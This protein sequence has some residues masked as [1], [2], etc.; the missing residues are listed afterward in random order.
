MNRVFQIIDDEPSAYWLGF[1][2]ADG[3]VFPTK[4]GRFHIRAYQKDPVHLQKLVDWVG[5]G[6][7]YESRSK[8]YVWHYAAWYSKESY[9]D[10]VRLGCVPNK[11]KVLLPPTHIPDS[12]TRHLIRGYND[13]DGGVYPAD[14][15]I[16]M[17][18]TVEF[19]TWVQ[20]QLPY[21][22]MVYP[23]GPTAQLFTCGKVNAVENARWLYEGA[24]CYMDKKFAAAQELYG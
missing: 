19:L 9:D 5:S 2:L 22:S 24:E 15:R 21:K 3:N 8:Q 10:L 13:G 14:R 1:M 6:K 7:I 11:S 20:E 23:Q 16:R 18:G 12:L 4:D 17:R